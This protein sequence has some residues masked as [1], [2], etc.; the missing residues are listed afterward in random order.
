MNH[1]T[2]ISILIVTHN[3]QDY[4][5]DLILSL[6]KFNYTNTYFCDAFS[7]DKTLSILQSNE[8]NL[9][10]KTVLEGF[11][12]N[13]NDLIRH[14]NLDSKYYLLLN[15]DMFFDEDFIHKLYLE[16]EANPKI[17]ITTPLL[18]YPNNNIQTTWKKF[19]SV[20]H[21]LKK[22]LGL[23]KSQ[24]EKQ[25]QSEYIDWCLGACML[26]SNKLLKQNQTLL[27]ERYRLYCEDVDIC[28]EAKQ[29]DLLVKGVKTAKAFHHH[30]DMN[31]KSFFSKYNLWNLQSIIKFALKW[32]IK[33]YAK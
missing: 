19:P 12:K 23:I 18:Y 27:D 29:K 10:K 14:F 32:N 16:I 6:K 8:V 28:F 13:N 3:H 5:E 2:D 21:V 33:Y 24:N 25:L 15:P 31:S 30:N 9:L 7:T 17:G 1:K 26:I 20:F 22:R 4:I 11:S